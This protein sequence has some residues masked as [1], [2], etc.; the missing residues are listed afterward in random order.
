VVPNPGNGQNLGILLKNAGATSS[1][2]IITD[3]LGKVISDETYESNSH[4]IRLQTELPSGVYQALILN[5]NEKSLQKI[6]VNR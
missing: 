5:G 2:V 6:V 1:R 4:A 3:M